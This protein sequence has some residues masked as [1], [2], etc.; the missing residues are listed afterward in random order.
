MNNNRYL[1]TGAAGFIGSHLMRRLLINGFDTLGIDNYS[2]YYS[3][4]YKMRRVS[5]LIE[6]NGGQVI[7]V[8]LCDDKKVREIIE[9]F[10]PTHIIHLAA[11]AGVRLSVQDSRKYVDSNLVAFVNILTNS[12]NSSVEN[13]IY[14]SSSSVYGNSAKLPYSERDNNLY[15]LSFYGVTKL[16]NELMANVLTKDSGIKTRGLRF[17]T[18]Y[19]DYGRPDM[20]YFK[21]AKSLIQNRN[22]E[23]NGDGTIKRDFTNIRDVV[24]AIELLTEELSEH[25]ASFSDIV[26]IGGGKPSSI[27]DLISHLERLS[28]KKLEIINKDSLSIDSLQTESDT[29]Y[30]KKLTGFVPRIELEEGLTEFWNWMVRNNGILEIL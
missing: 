1:I 21:I 13:F 25:D 7:K 11:Q 30:L 29:N 2:E 5:E 6:A 17:F 16:T 9:Q 10:K 3:T 19:G 12:I 20:A 26:N 24:E 28:G 14:A 15:P 23:L 8:E 18:A 27:N 22:F 4:I